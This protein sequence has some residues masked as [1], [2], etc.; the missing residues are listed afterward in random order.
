MSFLVPLGL[1][2]L[3]TV[4]LIVLLH[5]MRERRRRV[6]VPSLLL[7]Q[8]LPPRQEAQQ[9]RRLPL[10][11]L[12]L[13]HILAAAALAFALAAPVFTLNLFG[14]ERHLAY[15][16]D[17]STSMAAPAPGLGTGSRLQA[18]QE[19]VR[20]AVNGLGSRDSLTLIA[21]GPTPRL[22]AVGGAAEAPSL[23]TALAEL[24][25][26]GTG[27]DLPAALTLAEAALQDRRGARIVVLTDAAIP[28]LAADVERSPPALP[29]AWTLVGGPLDN[30]ALVT[31]AARPR[32]ASGPIQVY[33]R[34]VN[35]GLAP[36]RA[37]LQLYRD[38][39]LI[40]TR[41]LNFRPDGEI[42]LT[43]TLPP[44][45]GLLRAVIDGNDGLPADDTIALNLKQ[46]RP[47]RALLVS[48]AP[49]ELE[50]ALRAVPGLELRVTSPA[51]YLA[52][53]GAAD[54]TIFDGVLPDAWPEGGVLAINP[55]AQ[56]PLL[57]T[58]APV[59]VTPPLRAGARAAIL[60]GLSLGSLGIDQVR[61]V[62]A[63]P[64]AEIVLADA[65][66][67][68]ILR[69]QVDRSTVAVWAFDPASGSLTTRLA[70]P[71]L[72][73]RTVRDLVPA[74]PPTAA[75]L[76]A[77][78]VVVPDPRADTVQV[79]APD[80]SVTT[81]AVTP[82]AGIPLALMQPGIYTLTEL[83]GTTTIYSTALPVN[84]GAPA[85]SALGPRP[86][87]DVAPIS[88]P[89][90]TAAADA[91]PQQLWPWLVF[92]ALAVLLFEWLYVHGSRRAPQEV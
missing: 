49:A 81:I 47:I 73:A 64:W 20:T 25:A 9:R 8:L 63:P 70:F 16:V 68:L 72:V 40:D 71:L 14:A 86:L 44:G 27:A 28:T 35:Y 1:L 87:P 42:E 29:V 50:R 85:E 67:P 84:A 53:P 12:L 3:L 91:Q 55:P 32:G 46:F 4:P 33:G 24:R 34:A 57:S 69:G 48:A 74:A 39:A 2:A 82:G 15:V 92:L 90:G 36:T 62:V 43:W 56:H 58:D 89:G 45:G 7:W 37:T 26:G 6:V 60:D 21:A 17:T 61:P 38:E 18:A 30:R 31:L 78:L 54:L 11:L 22:L 52:S 79:R 75:L 77:G 5:L 80:D 23:L 59:A 41:Q 19:A 66:Q 51:S 10:T 83:A 65:N 88:L 13:L 76:G